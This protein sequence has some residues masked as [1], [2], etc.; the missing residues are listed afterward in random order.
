MTRAFIFSHPG[1][2]PNR[3]VNEDAVLSSTIRSRQ[4]M[5]S[6]LNEAWPEGPILAAVADGMGGGAGWSRSG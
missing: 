3:Q 4:S 5:A 6:P 2:N 1:N